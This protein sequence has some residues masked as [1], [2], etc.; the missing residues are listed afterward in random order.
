MINAGNVVSCGIH[1]ESTEKLVAYYM[2]D[3]SATK[4]I[5]TLKGKAALGTEFFVPQTDFHNKRCVL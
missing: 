5:F 3:A 1:I 2:F 4:D